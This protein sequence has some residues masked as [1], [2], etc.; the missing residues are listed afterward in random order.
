MQISYKSG[1]IKKGLQMITPT[2]MRAARAML[3]VPQGHVAEHLGIAAN[4]LSK[5]ESG[6][7]DVSMSRMADIQR[8]YEREGVAFV[9]NE[10]VKWND[11]LVTILE[12]YDANNGVLD[13]IYETLKDSGGEVLIAGLS[14][15]TKQEA[16]RYNF[17]IKHIERLKKTGITERMIIEEGDTNLIA[18]KEWYRTL[19]KGTFSNTPFQI[20]GD[21]IAMKEWGPPQRIVIIEHKRFAKT[22]RAMFDYVWDQ[23][24]EID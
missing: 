20:Y 16:D 8:F 4:T 14:E 22:F 19:P 21:K 24:K 17:L 15:V 7:S 5:I 10:G 23:A 12:G 11:S 2:Q 9:E 1:E 6:Q 3:D 18:P 13:D